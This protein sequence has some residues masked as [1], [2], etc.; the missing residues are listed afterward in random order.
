MIMKKNKEVQSTKYQYITNINLQWWSLE[1]LA[2]DNSGSSDWRGIDPLHSKMASYR[3]IEQ[4]H[5]IIRSTRFGLSAA[6]NTHG[7]IIAQM[8]SF[9]KNDKVMIVNLPSNKINT[10]YSL[11]GDL[12]VYLNILLL[13]FYIFFIYK[14]S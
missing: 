7:E 12:F 5:S 3:A 1:I 14:N 4:G 11:I 8:S 9:D 13:L 10:L 6:I 2:N